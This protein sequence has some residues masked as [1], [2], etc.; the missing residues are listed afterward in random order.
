MHTFEFANMRL[1]TRMEYVLVVVIMILGGA[2][3]IVLVAIT[4]YVS[5][6]S[7]KGSNVVFLL[8]TVHTHALI[9]LI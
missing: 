5:I 2:A 1:D 8:S 4:A 9:Q 6:P 7:L 3:L